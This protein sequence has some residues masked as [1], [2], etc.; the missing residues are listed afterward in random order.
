MKI[1]K[2][3]SS[4]KYTYLFILFISFG[5]QHAWGQNIAFILKGKITNV[6]MEAL[7]GVNVINQESNV[8]TT[9]NANGDFQI[10]VLEGQSL[11]FSFIGYDF[12]QIKVA[13]T[14]FLN[15]RLE[16]NTKSLNDVVVIGY[17]KVFRKDLTGSIES[18]SGKEI[19]KAMATDITEA[20]NGRVSGV[21][22]TKASNRPGA[23]MNIQIRGASSFNYSN[24]PLYVIDGVPSQSGMRNLNSVD[25]ESIDILKDASSCAIYGSRGAHGVV[26]IT[27]KG[28]L[29]KEGF[30]IEY[31]GSLG[32]KTPTRMPDMIGSKGNGMD[33]VNFRIAQWTTKF[34]AASLSS[35]S[36][37][38]NE[39]RNHVKYGEYYDWLRE[40]SQNALTSNNSILVSGGSKNTSYTFGIGYN[41]DGGI[42]GSEN[43]DRLTTNI[44]LEQ[45]LDN[46]IKI[47]INAYVSTNKINHGSTDALFSAYLIAPIVGRFQANG[48]PTFSHRPDG[49]VNPFIQNENT[50]NISDGW[51]T[52]VSTFME[53]KPVKSIAFKSQFSTQYDGATSGTWDGTNSQYG[54]GIKLPNASRSEG[55]NK[56]WVWDNTVTYDAVF[57]KIHKINAIGLF[58]YQKDTHTSSGMV[59]E[60]LPYE[61]DWNAIQTADQIT[62]V[63]SNYWE[64]SMLSFMGRL[65][66]VLLDRFLFTVTARYDGTSRLAKNNR[67]GLLPSAAV[68]W[69]LKNEKFLENARFINNLKL[70][71]SWGKTGNNNVP[72]DVTLTRLGLGAYPLGGSGQKG[73]GLGNSI[74][75]EDLKWEMTSEFN[76]GVD[77]GFFN[78][79]ISGSV[80]VYNRTTSGLIMQRQVAALNGYNNILQNIGSTSNKGIELGL[81]TVNISTAN[82]KW[83]TNLTFSKNKN[84]ILDLDGTKQSDLANRRFI[85]YP[86]NVYYDVESAGIWQENEKDLAAKY[87]AAPGW[88][89]IVDQNKD[90]IIDA[91]DY[92]ILG[93]PIPNWTGGMTNSLSYKNW[94]MSIFIYGRQG[95]LY[96]DPFTY[97]F[98]GIN[99]QDWNKLAVPYWTP[100]NKN[101]KYPGIGLECLYTQVLAQ[102][103]GSFLKVQNITVGYSVGKELIKKINIKGIRFYAAI[104][105]P[106]TFSSYL[107]SDPE[108]IG[109]SLEQQLSLYPLTATVGL[110]IKF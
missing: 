31:N 28:A 94:D 16:E 32:F 56:N 6:Q 40:F 104:Q 74:G 10:K 73:F 72:Y 54:Q 3:F 27:T 69:Q 71:A 109:E 46:K 85:G 45:R 75:N 84:A 47:G 20:L 55:T 22:V 43:F 36:F 106:F 26:I 13:N 61:S 12:K 107:G 76:Y 41:R 90:G 88:P 17:G 82:F 81:N 97:F 48:S 96:S 110:N 68:G 35:P 49:R 67:W 8:G 30:N 58:S 101:N 99:N 62:N 93:A 98:T 29:K 37:L 24:E 44:G 39:E 89:K 57:N 42:A 50:K 11:N 19:V 95:G 9:T 79:R 66:Y 38:T 100:Q 51:S 102:V 80:D 4:E 25:I 7:M 83:T 52:N 23:D 1:F 21:L 5:L 59:G 70:R 63:N 77:F 33:Y 64:S 18:I 65:N 53:Y 2:F 91:K 78:N 92:K 15:I 34:G 86:I 105:N 14:G 103:P 60:G 108:I 87:N